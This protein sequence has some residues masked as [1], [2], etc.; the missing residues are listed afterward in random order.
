METCLPV[1]FVLLLVCVVLPAVLAVRQT[2]RR[3]ESLLAK[4]GDPGLVEQLLRHRFWVGMTAE[5]LLDS[6]GKPVGIDEKVLKSKTKQTWK[7]QP[8]GVN[9]YALRIHLDN[10]IVVGWD[11]KR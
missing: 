10:E 2:R 6:R 9:R 1:A 4:Y 11:D 7:Y 5:Q 8:T 3:R